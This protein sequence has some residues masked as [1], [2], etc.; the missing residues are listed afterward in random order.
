MEKIRSRPAVIPAVV[1]AVTKSAAEIATDKKIEA[2]TKAFADLTT[3]QRC[4]AGGHG[5]PVSGA[6]ATRP[7][8]LL[9]NS[10]PC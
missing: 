3:S 6:G 8:T 9:L 7:S 10:Q 1:P 5:G 4:C 2:L